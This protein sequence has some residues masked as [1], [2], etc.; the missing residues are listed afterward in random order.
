MATPC[1]PVQFCSPPNWKVDFPELVGAPGAPG[2]PG[3]KGGDGTNGRDAPTEAKVT[4]YGPIQVSETFV[5]DVGC[6]EPYTVTSAYL[7]VRT[8]SLVVTFKINGVAITGL[9]N[10]NVGTVRT[11]VHASALNALS[12]GD[13]LTV[14]IVSVTAGTYDLSASI[15]VPPSA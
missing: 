5:I 9:T 14:E 6:F 1:A 12:T 2:A 8:G 10:I 4:L 15:N 13:I 11:L 3:A 7:A